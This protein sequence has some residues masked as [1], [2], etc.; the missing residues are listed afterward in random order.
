MW[1]FAVC[2]NFNLNNHLNQVT[3]YL[4]H[5]SVSLPIIKVNVAARFD[6]KTNPYMCMYIGKCCPQHMLIV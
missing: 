6:Y 4:P 3:L 2:L 1:N 5:W